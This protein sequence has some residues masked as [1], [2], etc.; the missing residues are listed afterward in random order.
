MAIAI[1]NTGQ[2]NVGSVT[3]TVTIAS[4]AVGS[5]LFRLLLVGVSYFTGTTNPT[6]VV[7][8]ITFNGTALTFL[9]SNSAVAFG[10]NIRAELWYMK[11]PANVTASIVITMSA[12]VDEIIC[13]A[14]SWTGVDQTSTFGTVGKNNSPGGGSLPSVVIASNATAVVHDTIE[15]GD[16]GTTLTPSNTQRWQQVNAANAS[17]GL[18]QSAPGA[19][20]VTLSWTGGGV[21]AWVGLGVGINAD[22]TAVVISSQLASAVNAEYEWLG[23]EGNF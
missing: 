14:D 2:S 4:F 7:S 5:G 19:T 8:G 1:D 21:A 17:R 12:A 16:Q 22:T 15:F 3:T 18:G 20:S 10:A 11:A 9:D 13:G 6:A 23:G